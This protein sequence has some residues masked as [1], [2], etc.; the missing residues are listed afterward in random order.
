MEIIELWTDRE[1]KKIDPKLFS[2]RAESLA[3]QLADDYRREKGDPNKISQIR[4][5]YDEVV[6][7]NMA[8]KNKNSEW[9]NILPMVNMIIA[10]IA[11]AKGR[12]LISDNFLNF[13]KTS[14]KQIEAPEDLAVFANLFE[15]F[16]GFYKFYCPSNK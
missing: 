5:F 6:R 16:Y 10:K 13:M 4:K 15:A 8:A 12:N 7:L 14:I 11:Y 9:D 1:N 2:D 3:K